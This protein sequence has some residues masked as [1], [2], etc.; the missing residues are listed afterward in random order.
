MTIALPILLAL[1]GPLAPLDRLV[2][3]C[4]TAE[5]ASGTTDRHC[6]ALVYGGA[7]VRDTHEVRRGGTVV[8]AGETIYSAEGDAIG[9][10]YWNS[11]GGVGRGTATVVGAMITF[12]LTMRATPAATPRPITTVWRMTADGYDATTGGVVRHFRRDD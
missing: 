10:T 11:L 9:F 5:V 12:R 8:Y 4:W 2:G 1:S 7:H 3:H 6:Y